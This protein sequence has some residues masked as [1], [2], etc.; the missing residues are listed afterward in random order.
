MPDTQVDTSMYNT[1]K[2]PQ[3]LDPISAMQGI[4]KIQLTQQEMDYRKAMGPLVQKNTDANGQI[5]V[6]G[7]IRDGVGIPQ[8]AWKL[9]ELTEQLL[10]NKLIDHEALSKDIA[11]Q[12]ARAN[13]IYNVAS[14]LAPKGANVTPNDLIKS[15]SDPAVLRQLGM[16]PAQ[17]ID[18]VKTLQQQGVLSS[19]AK[20]QEYI[21]QTQLRAAGATK[22]LEEVNSRV[23]GQT[24]QPTRD[25]SGQIV[26]PGTPYEAPRQTVPGAKLLGT[27]GEES[28]ISPQTPA[29]KAI[30]TVSIKPGA[31]GGHIMEPTVRPEGALAPA[32]VGATA[33]GKT[34]DRVAP[35]DKTP[36]VVTGAAANVEQAR[37]EFGREYE[38]KL[39]DRV[40]NARTTLAIGDQMRDIAKKISTGGGAQFRA[41][42]AQVA[43]AL[44]MPKEITDAIGNKNLADSQV[45]KKFAIQLGTML[46][47]SLIHEG[48][49]RLA[50][51]EWNKITNEAS[52]QLTTDPRAIE[53]MIKFANALAN[54]NISEAVA[55]RQF[56]AE[57]GDVS[58]WRSEWASLG[59]HMLQKEIKDMNRTK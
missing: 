54:I 10:K 3:P 40:A 9:P 13:V 27:P 51:Q 39:A 15:L 44:N 28:V 46:S 29:Q 38:P 8:V 48:G 4:Q 24:T 2:A 47:T 50:M 34:T 22:T 6:A 36:G 56:K 31:N 14:G 42:V 5:N 16:T 18:Y 19:G 26:P 49:G 45:F 58:Q 35:L 57:G 25:A 23:K 37:A 7:I 41:S 30:P 55:L 20:M 53:K 11:N 17:A 12:T 32:D 21:L 52:P 33:P 59:Y 43:Q 1:I